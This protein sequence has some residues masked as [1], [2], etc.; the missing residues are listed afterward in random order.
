M[1]KVTRGHKLANHYRSQSIGFAFY[2]YK[3][4][5]RSY[6]PTLLAEFEPLELL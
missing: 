1:T 3:K 2:V 5:Q 4:E 6:S